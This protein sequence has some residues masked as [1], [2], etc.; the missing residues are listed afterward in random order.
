MK[1]FLLTAL[2]LLTFPVSAQQPSDLEDLKLRLMEKL[3][4][5]DADLSDI[6]RELEAKNGPADDGASALA[7]ELQKHSSSGPEDTREQMWAGYFAGWK[8]AQCDVIYEICRDNGVMIENYKSTFERLNSDSIA[9]SDKYL[10]SL[11]PD[12]RAQF[13]AEM[14]KMKVPT[15]RQIASALK[16]QSETTGISM[17]DI[18]RETDRRAVEIVTKQ[19]QTRDAIGASLWGN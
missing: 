19:N 8:M 11:P 2:C 6:M 4:N 1:F 12:G 5:G 14:E 18:C 3:E 15:T 7:A 16:Q 13:L 10:A 17:Q 9:R